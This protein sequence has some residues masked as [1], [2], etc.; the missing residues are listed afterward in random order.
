MGKA[1]KA[2]RH[3]R[4]A[5]AREAKP[6]Q[7]VINLTLPPPWTKISD[8]LIAKSK[9]QASGLVPVVF[10]MPSVPP[11]VIPADA[12]KHEILAND[13]QIIEA[14]AWA[15]QQVY[16]GAFF[17]G[18]TWLGYTYLSE[19]AQRPEY[20]RVSEVLATEATRKWIKLQST[21]TDD[22][23]KT[24]RIADLA[25]EM[26]RLDIQGAFRKMI[27]LDGLFGRAHLYLDTGDTDNRTELATSIGDGSDVVTDNKFG[28]RKGFLR[29]VKPIEPVWCY[30]AKYN[31]SDP[32]KPDWY[33]PQSWFC[34]GKEIHATRLLTFVGREVPDLLKPSYSFGG[35]SLSQ[36]AKPYIDNWLRTRQAVADLIW[37]FSVRGLSTD[38]STMM[39]QDGDQLFKRAALFANMQTNQGLMLLNKDT[40]EFFQ[41]STPLGTLDALQAAAQ[42]HICSVVA[43]PGVKLLGIQ[44]QGFNASSEGE[45]MVWYDWVEAFQEKFIT[46][47]LRQVINFIMLSLWG[48]VDDE[49]TFTYESLRALTEKEQAEMRKTEAETD[50]MLIEAGVLAPQESRDRLA[51]DPDSPYDGLGDEDAPEEPFGEEAEGMPDLG[52]LMGQA[53]SMGPR[54]A[55]QDRGRGRGAAGDPEADR[56][57]AEANGPERR[58][59]GAGATRRADR[60]RG[61][62]TAGRETE[63]A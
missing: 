30:P 26:D 23:T 31:A 9:Y 56:R 51:A 13:E 15:A 16:D 59:P 2:A 17:N 28:G 38:L 3:A 14:N 20:R 39:A 53:T 24:Q 45:M 8:T 57:P 47:R 40:E 32:L 52:S 43:T 29:A 4:K 50:V 12:Q 33:N 22:E 55:R 5:G 36:M 44:P 60:I 10:K 54:E 58:A 25:A 18:V 63:D 42:E 37:S 61:T 21:T 49:I 48:E 35:L 7:P 41:I 11:G 1:A 27:E 46:R 19:I 62:E 34:Q 6:S